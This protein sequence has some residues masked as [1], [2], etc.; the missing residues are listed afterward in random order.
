MNPK[1]WFLV[2]HTIFHNGSTT[3]VMPGDYTEAECYE[4]ADYYE[5]QAR[6]STHETDEA[7]VWRAIAVCVPGPAQARRS[8]GLQQLPGRDGN[9]ILTRHNG[10]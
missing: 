4:A 1:I 2:L 7:M 6:V 10:E 9:R 3:T 8:G 5:A